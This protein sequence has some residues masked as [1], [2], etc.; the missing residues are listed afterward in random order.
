MG[1]YKTITKV[2]VY[3]LV[4]MATLSCGIYTFSGISIQS[5]VKSISVE[6]IEN[7]AMRV[8]PALSNALTEALIDQ[9]RRFTSLEIEDEGDMVVSGVVTSYELTSLAVTAQEQPSMNRLTVQVRIKFENKKYPK[10]NF[11]KSFAAFED[12]PSLSSFDSV[13][14]TIVDEIVKKLVKDIF[15]NTVARW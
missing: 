12:Y 3:L 15:N 11:E 14:S 9:Y 13:E 10:D 5:D 4:V 1:H 8:N 2:I 6:A 7:K